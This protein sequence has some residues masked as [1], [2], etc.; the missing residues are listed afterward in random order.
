VSCGALL[1]VSIIELSNTCN[2]GSHFF[3]FPGVE[4]RYA[5]YGIHVCAGI[6]HYRVEFSRDLMLIAAS[7]LPH[8]PRVF[9]QIWKDKYVNSEIF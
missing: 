1:V 5:E 2:L 4:C 7:L 8:F 6:C 3:D 9:S